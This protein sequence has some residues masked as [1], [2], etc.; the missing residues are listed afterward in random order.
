[1]SAS[2][3]IVYTDAI[4][5]R[6]RLTVNLLADKKQRCA[7]YL[8]SLYLYTVNKH[9]ARRSDKDTSGLD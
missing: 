2:P 6:Y 7:G 5:R 9:M 1:M 8:D 4:H 3:C